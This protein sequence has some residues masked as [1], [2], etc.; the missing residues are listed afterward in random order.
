MKSS[1]AAFGSAAACP[2]A[3]NAAFRQCRGIEQAA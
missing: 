2:T 1:T 3:L